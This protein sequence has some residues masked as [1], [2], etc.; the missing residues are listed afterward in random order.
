MRSSRPAALHRCNLVVAEVAR[1][2]GLPVTSV[3]RS[4]IDTW[5]EAHR[6]RAV[7][8]SDGVAR[9]AVF[10]A[11]R[12]RRIAVAELQAHVDVR[13][14]AGTVGP[15]RVL[16]F[17]AGGCES[18]LEIF[19]VRHVLAIP[20]LPP[21]E[22]QH[23]LLLPGGPVRLDAAWPEA[24]IAVE[25]D[26]A[27]FHSSPEARE[28]DLRR[29]AALALRLGW[30]CGSA[31]A[32]SC[33][34]R[35]PA[36]QRS[37]RLTVGGSALSRDRPRAPSEWPGEGRSFPG[38]GTIGGVPVVA[39]VVART[40]LRLVVL[41]DSIAYGTGARS[42]DDSLGP[43]LSAVLAGDGFDVDLHVLAVPGA[44]SAHL[45]AQVRRAEP[46]RPDLAVVVIGAN[47]LARFVPVDRPPPRS[48][49]VSRAAGGR[50][51]RRRRPGARHV[52]DPVRAAG[53]P[54]RRSGPPARCSSSS[55]RAAAEAAGA[56]V[57][58]IAVEVGG[59][60]AAR[61]GAVLRRPLPPVLGGLPR[62][63]PRRWPR[64]CSPPPGRAGDAAA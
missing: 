58:H 63:S 36:G 26:G 19:A 55:R 23:R 9:D 57:A 12:E 50:Q 60:F 31:I 54:A 51:R 27:A 13:R 52:L 46:L 32:G 41:G 17:I 14:A 40:P 28:R 2:R 38:P 45:A 42:P 21:C 62:T 44:V 4:L 56:T 53:V 49:R 61:P 47:D 11:T 30:C 59:A 3:A 15:G 5:G 10:R 37:S 34:S 64:P 24:K 43:R 48:A 8:G 18:P 35:R 7:R 1:A 25:L 33:V 29:D 16:G 22:Q 20:G 39:P 6:T